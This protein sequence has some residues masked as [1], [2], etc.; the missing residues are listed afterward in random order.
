MILDILKEFTGDDQMRGTDFMMLSLA[1]SRF[2][3][4]LYR[5]QNGIYQFI[6]FSFFIIVFLYYYT[7]IHRTGVGV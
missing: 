6:L 5:M 7:A 1:L 2:A 4:L 3:I